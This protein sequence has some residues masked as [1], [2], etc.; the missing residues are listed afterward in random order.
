MALDAFAVSISRTSSDA[1]V[2]FDIDG[3][4][5]IDALQVRIHVVFGGDV[6]KP[7]ILFDSKMKEGHSL[8]LFER[9]DFLSGV[10]MSP[11]LFS[12]FH[13]SFPCSYLMTSLA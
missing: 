8:P 5:S 7:R 3:T 13:F 9:F 11:I 10:R 12:L 2:K 1:S 6:K 4:G